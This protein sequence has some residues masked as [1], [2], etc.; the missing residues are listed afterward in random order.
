M[1]FNDVVRRDERLEMI[2]DGFYYVVVSPTGTVITQHRTYESASRV[3]AKYAGH[4]IY[5][6]EFNTW[7]P[8]RQP[9]DTP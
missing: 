9:K 3:A 2:V 1:Q 6:L 4:R 8:V 5:D 7:I